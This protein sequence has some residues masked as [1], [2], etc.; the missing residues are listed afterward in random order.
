MLIGGKGDDLI[1]G[2]DGND[3]AL[4]GAGDDT[5]VWN[6]GDDNDTLEGQ[7][8][9]DTMLFNG[10]NVAENID[11]L[12]NGGRALFFRDVAAVTMDLNDVERSTSTRWAAPTTSSSTTCRAPTSSEVNIDLGAP[13]RRRRRR[14]RHRDLNATNGDDVILVV[15][16]GTTLVSS[17]W[18][19]R[20][21]ITNFEAANDRLVIN[22]LAG[23]DVIEASRRA[24]AGG[25]R[26]R[27][28]GGRRRAGRRRRQ[29]RAR[30]G[31]GDDVLIG[32][33]GNDVLERREPDPVGR[34]RAGRPVAVVRARPP[35]LRR[36]PRA[37]ARAGALGSHDLA[38]PGKWKG[39]AARI[40]RSPYP[41]VEIPGAVFSRIVF[42][43]LAQLGRPRGFL[44]C[45]NA[46]SFPRRHP[47]HAASDPCANLP[48]P[49][50]HALRC[51]ATTPSLQ[52][53]YTLNNS[54]RISDM[55]AFP[56]RD[57]PPKLFSSSP[58]LLLKPLLP[59]S[60]HLLP[61]HPPP[62]HSPSLSPHLS[63]P[64]SSP[65]SPP[66]PPPPLLPPPSSS[67]P[68]P[69]SS[70]SPPLPLSSSSSPSSFP[71]PP[72]S[73]LPPAHLAA[74]RVSATA[75]CTSPTARPRR[76]RRRS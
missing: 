71:P 26:R 49:P 55:R 40:F 27:R 24:R 62:L 39:G 38:W 31:A 37:S 36:R 73:P 67:P 2:G 6:P 76:S 74:A 35:S 48:S 34:R 13:R 66:L 58:D 61:L 69:F 7:A 4:M 47:V 22:G 21:C 53:P 41:P 16:S 43:Q 54:G 65:L 50:F 5:F 70:L 51:G 8:G 32:G 45:P 33:A 9:F 64:P 57:T 59:S 14:G 18:R 72:P 10:A 25:H 52:P 42:P 28:R 1:N 11:I 19:R 29:R 63:S 17:A 15:W 68:P 56:I 20:S 44:H 75:S 30:G 12:A 3:M 23:D 60:P 46:I